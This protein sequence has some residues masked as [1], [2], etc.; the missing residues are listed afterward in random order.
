MIDSRKV[1][2]VKFDEHL[3]AAFRGASPREQFVALALVRILNTIPS[4]KDADDRTA[5]DDVID[6]FTDRAPDWT[7]RVEG[8][9][10]WWYQGKTA[11]QLRDRA[12]YDDERIDRVREAMAVYKIE[13]PDGEDGENVETLSAAGQ[14]EAATAANVKSL[15]DPTDPTS[16]RAD[17]EDTRPNAET[18]ADRADRRDQLLGQPVGTSNSGEVTG[19]QLDEANAEQP[20]AGNRPTDPTSAP[21]DVTAGAVPG[22]IEPNANPPAAPA[23]NVGFDVNAALDDET[24]IPDVAGYKWADV[25]D[26]SDADLRKLPRMGRASIDK[27]R[28]TEA[29]LA[30]ARQ[31][32][33]AATPPAPAT[34]APTP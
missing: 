5:Y 7:A 10:A 12:G 13:I 14:R 11:K 21:D 24:L 33:A 16:P 1:A 2:Q 17:R 25:R 22:T 32:R 6:E 4:D 9:P 29:A 23:P 15:S 19:G 34:P 31:R 18:D 20:T 27:V 8:Q 26:K 28:T 30:D 3:E